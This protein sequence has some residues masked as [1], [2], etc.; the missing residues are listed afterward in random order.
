MKLSKPPRQAPYALAVLLATQTGCQD[1]LFSQ[2][3]P[4][5]TKETKLEQAAAEPTPADILFVVDNSGSMADDQ[6]N[7]ATSFNRFIEEIPKDGD[8]RMAIVS[9]DL[10]SATEMAGLANIRFSQQHPFRRVLF[11]TSSNQATCEPVS[12][13]HGCFRGPTTPVI[14]STMTKE[15]QQRIF[16]DNVRVGSCG[17]GREQGLG[18]MQ[19]ALRQAVS[20]CN[21]GFLRPEANLIIVIVSDEDDQSCSGAGCYQNFVDELAAIKEY[22]RIRIASIVGSWEGS[23]ADCRIPDNPGE[24]GRICGSLC[25]NKPPSSS[26][27]RDCVKDDNTCA[28]DEFCDLSLRSGPN[29][30]KCENIDLQNWSATNCKWCSEYRT[31][32]CC[33][34]LGGGRYVAFTRA[35]AKAIVADSLNKDVNDPDV[36]DQTCTSDPGQSVC[37][38][39]SICQANF[40]DTLARIARELVNVDEYTLSPPP[41]YPEGVVVRITG[42]DGTRELVQGTNYEITGGTKLRLLA[43]S[44]PEEGESVEIYFVTDTET[45][46]LDRGACKAV[47]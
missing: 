21:Q 10:T 14:D 32:D 20:G 44:K 35:L 42:Q 2:Q 1:Y 30:G 13:G 36:P 27:P 23:P 9:T 24:D 34:A 19:S 40:G 46:A 22:R 7:L 29:S 6:D 43:G 3:C 45:Q 31:E 18:A 28:A 25:N 39:E 26:N 5:I 11:D 38:I 12:T 47:P 15:D 17:A 37:L 16:T 4:A 8:Y 33:S 41:V